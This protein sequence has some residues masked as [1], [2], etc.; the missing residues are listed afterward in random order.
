[1]KIKFLVPALLSL[2]CTCVSAQTGEKSIG[3]STGIHTNL[4]IKHPMWGVS[5]GY[6]FMEDFRIV[7][8]FEYSAP[9]HDKV[10]NT[11]LDVHYLLHAGNAFTLY[12]LAGATLLYDGKL[13]IA[14]AFGAGFDYALFR[15]ISIGIRARYHQFIPNTD[16]LLFS[17]VCN[18]LF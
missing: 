7:P 10:W 12:T 13:H 1:M 9:L 17:A 18:Y 16:F 4:G 15:H 11:S 8:S 3:I 14:P 6:N 5:L 2:A